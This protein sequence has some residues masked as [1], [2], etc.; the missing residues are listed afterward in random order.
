MAETQALTEASTTA[1][2]EQA[3]ELLT[4]VKKFANDM[5]SYI[6]CNSVCN[7]THSWDRHVDGYDTAEDISDYIEAL[8]AGDTDR[9]AQLEERN[10]RFSHAEHKK[11]GN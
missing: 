3:V 6:P 7:G 9:V 1:P 4:R 5:D 10:K 8:L 2:S 11:N